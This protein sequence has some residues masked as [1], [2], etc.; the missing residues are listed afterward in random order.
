MRDQDAAHMNLG[1]YY[2]RLPHIALCW[3]PLV[4]I[5]HIKI[6]L[7]LADGR[8]AS[9]IAGELL[10]VCIL[11]IVAWFSKVGA[12]WRLPLSLTIFSTLFILCY[13][14]HP[15]FFVRF[16]LGPKSG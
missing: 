10:I 16:F 12:L 4:V 6:I 15:D 14:Q 2:S 13:L 7:A 3:M 9:Y 5:A 11:W 1:P 8:G